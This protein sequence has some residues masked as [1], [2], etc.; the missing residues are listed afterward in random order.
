MWFP[1]ASEIIDTARTLFDIYG[2]WFILFGATIEGLLFV[3]IYFPGSTVIGLGAVFARTGDL[4]LPLVIAAGALGLQI[5]LTVD[6]LLGRY[7]WYHLLVRLGLEGSLAKWQDR[8]EKYGLLA[9]GTAYL[10]P[11]TAALL[12]TSA[13]ILRV[14]FWKFLPASSVV[15]T[16]WVAVVCIA[17]YLVG[18]ELVRVL[19][20][21]FWYV[22][23]GAFFGSWLIGQWR[24]KKKGES[25]VKTPS[26]SAPR[27]HP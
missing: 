17:A 4:S 14:P 19:S 15:I 16:I 13:G 20:R 2:Y 10:I 11:T 7:G 3:T 23:F 1:S 18:E 26:E 27:R 22:F 6:Y 21:F 9:M 24:G 8:V 25:M 5:G 12:A